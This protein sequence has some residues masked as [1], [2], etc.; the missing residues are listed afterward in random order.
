MN[1]WQTPQESG[2]EENVTIHEDHYTGEMPYQELNELEADRWLGQC[3]KDI[4]EKLELP[5]DIVSEHVNRWAG[6][7]I[8]QGILEK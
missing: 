8:H 2:Y 3:V 7:A 6:Y 4:H 5:W 1:N